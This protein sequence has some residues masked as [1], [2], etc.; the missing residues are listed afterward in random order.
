MHKAKDENNSHVF[1]FAQIVQAAQITNPNVGEG[2]TEPIYL[3]NK[4][5]LYLFF[6]SSE[7]VSFLFDIIKK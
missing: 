6:E 7:I 5:F 1:P 4:L 3:Y 2:P